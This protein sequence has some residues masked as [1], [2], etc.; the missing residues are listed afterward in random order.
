MLS[1]IRKQVRLAALLLSTSIAMPT[2]TV[3]VA[4]ALSATSKEA[5]QDRDGIHAYWLAMSTHLLVYQVGPDGCVSNAIARSCLLAARLLRMS[6]ESHPDAANQDADIDA[7]RQRL[8]TLVRS[9]ARQNASNRSVAGVLATGIFRGAAPE[10]Q[11]LAIARLRKLEPDNL[12]AWLLGDD[13]EEWTLDRLEAAA[14]ATYANSR[15]IEDVRADLELLEPFDAPPELREG[16]EWIPESVEAH[17]LML[18]G[19]DYVQRIPRWAGLSEACSPGHSSW[20]SAHHRPCVQIGRILADRSDTLD[21]ALFGPV[22]LARLATTHEERSAAAAAR[23][24]IRYLMEFKRS[25]WSSPED[26]R[27]LLRDLRVEG[28]TELSALRGALAGAGLPVEPPV[29]WKPSGE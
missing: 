20:R 5:L 15:M 4:P 8:R 26:F 11:M 16:M 6:L 21:L 17:Q 12:Y 22:L 1:L 29:G 13:F 18:M 28:A 24:T 23:R 9:V 10:V 25:R 19:L 14:G 3:A 27:A 7:A 2:T